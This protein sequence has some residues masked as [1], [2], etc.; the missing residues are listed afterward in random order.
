[1]SYSNTQYVGDGLSSFRGT[2]K[3]NNGAIFYKH[4][5]TSSASVAVGYNYTALTGPTSAH[6]HQLNL[7]LDYL[8]SKQTDLYAAVGYQHTYGKTLNA[9]GAVVE[10]K[11]AVGDLVINSGTSSQLLTVAGIRHRF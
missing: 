5:F 2:A 1:M 4:H 6:C 10:A 3:F 8:L 11:A 9:A 7:G